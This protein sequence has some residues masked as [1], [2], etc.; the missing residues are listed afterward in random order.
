MTP[1]RALLHAQLTAD[2][3][4]LVDVGQE[5]LHCNGLLGAGL[6]ALHAADTAGGAGLPGVGPLVLVLAEDHRLPLVL[7]D[8]G[9]DAVG[10]RGGTGS[11]AVTLFLVDLNNFSNHAVDL[12][13]FL[14]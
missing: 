14:V 10:A 2:A 6:G 11:A 9:D 4:V 8:D 13:A 3:L 7:G 12:L 5:I 1:H